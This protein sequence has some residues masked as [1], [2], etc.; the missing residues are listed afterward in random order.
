MMICG[1]FLERSLATCSCIRNKQELD[2]T[3]LE[4]SLHDQ[5]LEAGKNLL[6]N[7]TYFMAGNLLTDVA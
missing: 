1:I 3:F 2:G 4:R 7:L 6:N 5:A